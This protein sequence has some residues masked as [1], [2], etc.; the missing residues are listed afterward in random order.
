MRA[1]IRGSERLEE[2]APTLSE[3]LLSR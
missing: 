1:R 2:L 3:M